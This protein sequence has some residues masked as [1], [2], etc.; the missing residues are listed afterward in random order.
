MFLNAIFFYTF[1][2]KYG[3]KNLFYCASERNRYF[4]EHLKDGGRYFLYKL[5]DF[6]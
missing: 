5:Q 2:Y 3:K 4:L 1:Q 6:F